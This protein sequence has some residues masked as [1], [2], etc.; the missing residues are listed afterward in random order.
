[1]SF[2]EEDRVGQ[3][4][5]LPDVIKAAVKAQAE[6]LN[7]TQL[8]I[9][10]DYDHT[11]PSCTVQPIFNKKFPDGTEEEAPLIYNV[12]VNFQ[13]A[14]KSFVSMPLKKGHYVTLNFTD[15]SIDKWLNSGGKVT[16]DDTRTH[17]LSDAIATP[18]GYPFSDAPSIANP[19]DVI[20][21]HEGDK[22]KV[23]FRMKDNGHLQI[24]NKQHELLSV[25]DEILTVLRE[26]VVYTGDAGAQR[27]RHYRFSTV[28]RKLKT[29]V[30]K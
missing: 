1:M 18:A 8:A 24:L 11:K 15:R 4:P 25:L 13:R 3:T 29:F 28:H 23:E 10:V 6:E 17:H 19:D 30:E 5:T 7:S 27:L 14:G 22:N 21:K 12:P 9:V 26:A 2:F 16:P 20:L